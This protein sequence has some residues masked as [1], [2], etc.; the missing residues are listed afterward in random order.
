VT[1]SIVILIFP[2]LIRLDMTGS[3]EAPARPPNVMAH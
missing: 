1:R 2:K 3:H